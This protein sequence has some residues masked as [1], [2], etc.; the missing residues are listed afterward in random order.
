MSARTARKGA[1]PPA[2]Q[3]AAAVGARAFKAP[4]VSEMIAAW[5]RE[6]VRR[7]RL[8]PGDPLPSEEE[9][10]QRFSASRPTV[11]EAMRLM[12][13]QRLVRITRGA[14]GGARYTIP[15]VAMVAQ[16]TGIYLQAHEASQGDLTA[17][18]L[19]IEP[20]IIGVIA[21][22]AD[23]HALLRL[24]QS[25]EQQAAAIDDLAAFSER[26]ERFYEILSE[27]CANITLSMLLLIFRELMHA[28]T[29]N[30]GE[31]QG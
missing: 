18:R 26:H 3:P 13:A 4:K 8:R 1:A 10:K 29:V 14:S 15:D 24:S 2:R 23:A 22:Q 5:L 17:A 9:L 27:I 6:Y 20:C 12:E 28:Q 11:R 19:S 7:N 25:V 31:A 30:L 16:H 21:E